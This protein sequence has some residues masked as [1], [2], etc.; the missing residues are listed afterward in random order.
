MSL[1]S[2]D[3]EEDDEEDLSDEELLLVVSLLSSAAAWSFACWTETDKLSTALSGVVASIVT[4]TAAEPPPPLS[5]S[6]LVCPSMVKYLLVLSRVVPRLL[7][8]VL[9]HGYNLYVARSPNQHQ[10]NNM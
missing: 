3:D 6:L 10:I 9:T 5:L 8:I 7:V 1:A 2:S 4:T